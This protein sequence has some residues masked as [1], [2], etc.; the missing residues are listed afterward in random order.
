MPAFL[1][2]MTRATGYV[3]V[4][5]L[6]RQSILSLRSVLCRLHHEFFRG[7]VGGVF[8]DIAPLRLTQI[9][10]SIACFVQG[11]HITTAG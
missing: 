9:L 8:A 6:R 7:V 4:P 1:L 10:E 5:D 3:V 2:T 11:E